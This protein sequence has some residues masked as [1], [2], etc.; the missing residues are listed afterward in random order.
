MSRNAC[1]QWERR[2]ELQANPQE[3]HI[4]HSARTAA[5]LDNQRMRESIPNNGL[6]PKLSSVIQRPVPQMLCFG[7]LNLENYLSD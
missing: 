1:D 2:S 5:S 3:K 6:K 4:L 7:G